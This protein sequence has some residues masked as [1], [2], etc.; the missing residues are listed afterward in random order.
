MLVFFVGLVLA[1][2]VTPFTGRGIPDFQNYGQ[3]NG[4]EYFAGFAVAFYVLSATVLAG[5]IGV[6]NFI[7]MAVKGQIMSSMVIDHFGLFGV[8]IR[9][10]NLLPAL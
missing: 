8:P 7:L 2:A 10:I 6:A 1:L 4:I 9:P 5:K 3:L